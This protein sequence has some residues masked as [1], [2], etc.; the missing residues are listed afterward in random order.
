MSNGFIRSCAEMREPQENIWF[1]A[2]MHFSYY[3]MIGA[4][5]VIGVEVVYALYHLATMFL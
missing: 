1:M 2:A 5:V 4:L 3:L